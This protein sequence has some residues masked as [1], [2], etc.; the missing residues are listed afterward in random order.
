MARYFALL[1]AI[2]V[3]GHVVKM[4]R[5]RETFESLGLSSVQ[6][7]IASGNVIF[8]S[9]ARNVVTLAN[10][11]ELRLREALGY[12]VITFLRT[13]EELAAIEAYLPFGT[14]DLRLPGNELYV[15]FLTEGLATEAKKKLASLENPIDSF[16]AHGREIYWLRRREAGESR[17]SGGVLE[18]AVGMP[19]TI[20]NMNTVRRL[21]KNY[22]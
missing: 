17:F 2:N 13:A 21:V 14:D 6:T 4:D 22:G 20:R 15:A 19:A 9:K 3:G 16:H 12:E 1:R 7:F 18:Q 5:L 10:R 8:E 11:I